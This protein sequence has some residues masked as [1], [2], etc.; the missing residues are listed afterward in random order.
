MA[1]VFGLQNLKLIEFITT[2]QLKGLKPKIKGHA[3]FYECSDLTKK[4]YLTYIG[5][6][7]RTF[8]FPWLVNEH[9]TTTPS[10]NVMQPTVRNQIQI[11][12]GE[13][14]IMT[15]VNRQ[16]PNDNL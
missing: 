7:I 12:T 15:N 3:N 5:C 14:V 10:S 4:V 13:M 1:F 11:S 8:G 6:T 2:F 16:L 9:S